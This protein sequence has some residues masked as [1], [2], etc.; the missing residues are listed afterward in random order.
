MSNKSVRS[1]ATNNIDHVGVT[2]N[3]PFEL[4]AA[5]EECFLR[6]SALV[7]PINRKITRK[8]VIERCAM[9]H[10][11]KGEEACLVASLTEDF[12]KRRKLR[13]EAYKLRERKF[14]A[15]GTWGMSN[16]EKKLFAECGEGLLDLE[17]QVSA[18][19]YAIDKVQSRK[20]W[21]AEQNRHR[22]PDAYRDTNE[23]SFE[24]PPLDAPH[25][26]VMTRMNRKLKIPMRMKAAALK[27]G[28]G[29]VV[30][31]YPKT[32]TPAVYQMR[33]GVGK[34]M[35]QLDKLHNCGP[36]AMSEFAK[37]MKHNP[38][39]GDTQLIN[40]M[41]G[42]EKVEWTD[43]N[44]K[45][46]TAWP[47]LATYSAD[48]V[49]GV[50]L[51]TVARKRNPVCTPSS[52]WA[53]EKGGLT[54][55]N[56]NRYVDKVTG[57]TCFLEQGDKEFTPALTLSQLD[58]NLL[59]ESADLE[60]ENEA[61]EIVSYMNEEEEF[62]TAIP[63]R[64]ISSDFVDF[65]KFCDTDEEMALFNECSKELERSETGV[66]IGELQSQKFVMHIH[67]QIEEAQARLDLALPNV[68]CDDD[69]THAM[70]A[71]M[72]LVK[73]YS[74]MDNVWNKYIG[75][76]PDHAMVKYWYPTNYSMLYRSLD[77]CPQVTKI[78]GASVMPDNEIERPKVVSHEL[79]PWPQRTFQMTLGQSKQLRRQ[80]QVCAA[81]LHNRFGMLV[82]E[83][84]AQTEFASALE[85]AMAAMLRTAAV[86]A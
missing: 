52:Y 2:E 25:C 77:F 84:N 66:T 22:Q 86:S 56:P 1:Y 68:V 4:V 29:V 69:I 64:E 33:L 61:G 39:G 49:K 58:Y 31:N 24:L 27:L 67:K 43:A 53:T 48:I 85:T 18:I 20:K 17:E 3:T 82:R 35:T 14:R 71:D 5:W 80:K 78:A 37:L 62:L 40:R 55:E 6:P 15:F 74:F 7:N 46:K 65:K 38:I 13:D 23:M 70:H 54:R 21:K 12:A 47:W 16:D 32:H 19:S 59:C 45:V 73:K 79:R 9:V 26:K 75:N 51:V 8:E 60:V 44:G 30:E 11:V 36:D 83:K 42:T 63:A 28:Y 10:L 50:W 34:P 81:I 57:E 76:A 41:M 72:K